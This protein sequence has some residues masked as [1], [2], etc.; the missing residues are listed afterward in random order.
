MNQVEYHDWRAD[1]SASGSAPFHRCRTC[2][3]CERAGGFCSTCL[4][5]EYLLEPH[6]HAGTAA[7]AVCPLPSLSVSTG[8]AAARTVG[9]NAPV[10]LYRHLPGA[11]RRHFAVERQ[12]LSDGKRTALAAARSARHGEAEAKGVQ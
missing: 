1:L 12:A 8:R 9:P 6:L 7:S 5:G 11:S 4:V 3:R 2:G 10:G